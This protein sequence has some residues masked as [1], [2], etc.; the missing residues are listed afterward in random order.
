MRCCH[1]THGL[2]F[3]GSLGFTRGGGQQQFATQILRVHLL[4]IDSMFG[5]GFFSLSQSLLAK[6]SGG[7]PPGDGIYNFPSLKG[8]GS[9]SYDLSGARMQWISTRQ[10]S[11]SN[12]HPPPPP[13]PFLTWPVFM[14]PFFLRPL[15]ATPFPPLFSAPS[16]LFPFLENYSTQPIM[17][18]PR[19]THRVSG[20]TQRVWCRTHWVLSFKTVLLN[21]YFARF[22]TKDFR[23]QAGLERTFLLRRT[24]RYKHCSHYSFQD[25]HTALV[26]RARLP[27]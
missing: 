8:W 21:L 14:R 17:C 4:G 15:L 20:K 7:E 27:L 26:R 2:L 9:P 25:F 18:V 19:R 11:A 22:L 24:G 12:L 5:G 16:H 1:T 10:D 6:W 3:R 23:L 13:T